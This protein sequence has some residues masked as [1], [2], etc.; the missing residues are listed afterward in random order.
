MPV[1][2]SRFRTSAQAG[3]L[4][5]ILLGTAV[6]VG[7]AANISGLKVVLAGK[8]SMK[9]NSAIGFLCSGLALWFLLRDRLSNLLRYICVACSLVVLI[10]GAL[11][12][13]EYLFHFDLRI[14]E[15][16]FADRLQ[17]PYPGR[18]AP[19]S[20]I[21]FGM[22]GAGL[23]L[24]CRRE[25]AGKLAQIPAVLIGLS[26]LLAVIGYA[27]GV[28][29]LYESSNYTSM[30]LPSGA[31]FLVLAWALLVCASEN[32]LSSVLSGSRPAGWLS[33]TLL[34]SAIILPFTLGLA[35]IQVSTFAGN[36][37]LILAALTVAEIVLFTAVIWVATSRL[38]ASAKKGALA[39]KAMAAS[40]TILNQ[41]QKMEAI[42]VLAG[43]LAH[44][45]NNLLNVIV[46]YSELLLKD[47]ALLQNQR[48][49]AEK[50]LKAGQTATALTR[51]LLA[52]SRQQVLQPKALDLNQLISSTDGYLHRL[53]KENVELS[54]ALDSGLMATI[55][56]PTQ[57]EQVLLNLVVNASDAMPHGGKLHIETGNVVLE[58]PMASDAG[59]RPGPFVRLTVTDTGIGMDEKTRLQIFEPFFTTKPIGKGTGLGLATVYGIVKQSGG[60]IQVDSK[61][62]RGTTFR[63]YLPGSRI[64]ARQE[65]EQAS[66]TENGGG[67]TILVVED[68]EPLRELILE[69]LE[70]MGYTALIAKDGAQAIRLCNQFSGTIELLLVDVVMPKMNG[71]EVVKRVKK[72]RSEIAVLFMSGYT[73]D[74]TLRHGVSNADV[75][76]I[77]K[78]FT[79]TELMHKIRET[80]VEAQERNAVRRRL[81]AMVSRESSVPAK[82]LGE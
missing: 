80:L 38:D 47:T 79:S 51:Q 59:V 52:F 77:Q 26:A 56:D 66:A 18:I 78:P 17:V 31:G 73:N 55:I 11:T 28:P 1:A 13:S 24:L 42:G 74:V 4:F 44:D 7:W 5:L 46:G 37:R 9:A 61:L 76:F 57:L 64:S 29:A 72:I 15:L 3:A 6:L 54:T 32:R 45:F 22:A 2:K 20:A 35:A 70:S 68:S 62:G 21:N 60:F 65:S 16:F 25:R 19:I 75:S 43:G 69:T 12:L 36:A 82:G 81:D 41:S 53:I 14:D 30:A 40:E 67:G 50:I 8:I 10:I 27:Y 33:R 58:N 63:I 39:Q 49:K 23:L 34:A 71:P 48:S